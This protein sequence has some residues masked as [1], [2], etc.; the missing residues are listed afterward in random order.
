MDR[1]CR[2]VSKQ[3]HGIASCPSSSHCYSLAVEVKA[4]WSRWWACGRAS[5]AP[6]LKCAAQPRRPRSPRTG[7]PRPRYASVASRVSLFMV[8]VA[9]AVMQPRCVAIGIGTLGVE[10]EWQLAADSAVRP[11]AHAGDVRRRGAGRR[12]M[13]RPCGSPGGRG[14]GR[15]RG[16]EHRRR[17]RRPGALFDAG[18]GAGR[19][20][21]DAAWPGRVEARRGIEGGYC[22]GCALYCTG[23]T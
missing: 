1:L 12:A 10:R 15:S 6:Y 3:R 9:N 2:Q 22:T 17:A 18:L 11:A 13:A 23:C 21:G 5:R 16:V 7:V 20:H 14:L 8:A 19:R 4:R